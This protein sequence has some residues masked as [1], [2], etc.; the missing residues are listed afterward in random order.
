MEKARD[1]ARRLRQGIALGADTVVVIDG[2]VLGKPANAA[3]ARRMLRRL[4]GRSHRVITAVALCR[5]GGKA[6]GSASVVTTVKFKRLSAEEI[7]WYVG[8]GE[9]MDKAGGYGIQGRGGLFVSSIRGSYSN[10]VGLPI[11]TVHGFLGS[12]A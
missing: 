3:S 7:E 4:S 9:P 11:E 10:V 12:P 6:I 8:T 5:A 1:V 2:A